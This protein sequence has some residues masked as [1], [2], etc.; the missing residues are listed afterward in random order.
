MLIIKLENHPIILSQFLIKKHGI[1]IDIIN[2]FLAFWPEHCI[3]I[4]A[5]F[6]LSLSSLFTK[7]VAIKIEED[8]TF[9]KMIK[10]GLKKDMIDFLQMLNKLSSNKKR[11]INKNKHKISM[12]ESSLRKATI[13]SL[14]NSDKK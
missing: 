13:S 11:Q 8:I 1:I 10:K 2:N 3:Y 6:L 9:E 14:K 7:I 4:R 5:T 12:G